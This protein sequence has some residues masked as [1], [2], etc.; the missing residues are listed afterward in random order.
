MNRQSFK[1][2]Y[3]QLKREIISLDQKIGQEV[4]VLLEQKQSLDA[5]HIDETRKQHHLRE[6]IQK[7]L[8]ANSEDK[9]SQ[10]LT[11][12]EVSEELFKFTK[13]ELCGH[14]KNR[15]NLSYRIDDQQKKLA[16]LEKETTEIRKQ[17]AKDTQ[18]HEVSMEEFYRCGQNVLEKLTQTTQTAGEKNASLRNAVEQQRT[19]DLALYEKLKNDCCVARMERPQLLERRTAVLL[20]SSRIETEVRDQAKAL[21]QRLDGIVEACCYNRQCHQKEMSQSEMAARNQF[22]TQMSS[23][24]ADLK[25]SLDECREAENQFRCLR[26]HYKSLQKTEAC[27]MNNIHTIEEQI[28]EAQGA[29]EK[30]KAQLAQKFAKEMNY[31]KCVL[32]NAESDVHNLQVENTSLCDRF[33][34]LKQELKTMEARLPKVYKDG[35]D[36]KNLIKEMEDQVQLEKTKR[37]NDRFRSHEV[38]KWKSK[39]LQPGGTTPHIHFDRLRKQMGEMSRK[40]NDLQQYNCD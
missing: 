36:A 31:C 40:L 8:S 29:R 24:Q 12:L 11:S 21:E 28:Q 32:Q 39:F 6:A 5:A 25:R 33:S 16:E 1:L 34:L 30:N 9:W 3:D 14:F 38:S 27:I 37:Q 13:S 2:D 20:E 18:S 4:I 19:E 17:G 7:K 23:V 15:E 35:D 22:D 26:E 10:L